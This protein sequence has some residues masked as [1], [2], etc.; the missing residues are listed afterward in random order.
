MIL[1]TYLEKSESVQILLVLTNFAY[2]EP[3]GRCQSIPKHEQV[4]TEP[5]V[6]I[7]CHAKKLKPYSITMFQ[8]S[9]PS[10]ELVTSIT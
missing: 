1:P 8:H 2:H 7:L 3:Q 6:S 4:A 5:C 9:E 10:K